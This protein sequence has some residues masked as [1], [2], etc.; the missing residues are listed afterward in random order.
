MKV[1]VRCPS[2]AADPLAA[3]IVARALERWPDVAVA[4]PFGQGARAR[5]TIT[6]GPKH[7]RPDGDA[8]SPVLV[9]DRVDVGGSSFDEGWFRVNAK[10]GRL[11]R[12]DAV[13]RSPVRLG[14]RRP[15]GRRELFS[16][17]RGGL[18]ER[19]DAPMADDGAC[20]AILGCRRCVTACTRAAVHVPEAGAVI[21][22]PEACTRCGA[23]AAACPSGAIQ[24]PAFS[25]EALAGLLEAVD[26]SGAPRKT[27]VLTCDAGAL[28]PEPWMVT[29]EVPDVG[30]VGPRWL[31]MAAAS[32]LGLVAVVCADA[33]CG[34][35]ERARR[36]CE[37]VA[38]A[39]GG[40]GPGVIYAEGR[41]GWDRVRAEHA[42]SRAVAS[43]RAPVVG[44]DP[45]SRYAR[46]LEVLR[47]GDGPGGPLGFSA[48][49]VTDACT[50]CGACASSCPRGSLEIPEKG[51]LRFTAERCTG[52]GL[53]VA[54][55]PE[56]AVTLLPAPRLAG[57]F[58]AAVIHRDEVVRCEGCGA[59]VEAAA[60]LRKVAPLLVGAA[61]A[62]RYCSG[63]KQK[64]AFD[65]R[66]G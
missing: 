6:S 28:A 2:C 42:S 11:S 31:A 4:G 30:L 3:G 41:P 32:T 8:I 48:L 50:L 43:P 58:Q 20:E 1:L 47:A 25:D 22:D 56:N 57:V 36:A 24:L 52:C 26:A 12:S 10:L 9:D 34:G 60:L 29:E 7:G 61:P 23:C 62:L 37:A 39:T 5:L 18:T 33:A 46:T 40:R 66:P 16:L 21:V 38:G 13:T 14:P 64:V 49:E 19:V 17:L 65:V 44:G 55:C 15:V 45:W 27:L 59:P 63:C 51:V 54:V 35:R 53:C